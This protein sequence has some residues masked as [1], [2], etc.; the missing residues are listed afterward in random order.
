MFGN[1]LALVR[2]DEEFDIFVK[3][4]MQ[5]YDSNLFDAIKITA[6][7]L[8]NKDGENF[9]ILTGNLTIS[10]HVSIYQR[11][12]HTP[13]TTSAQTIKEAIH[14]GHYIDNEC[15]I[16]LLTDVYSDTKMNER[17]RN[18]LTREKVIEIIGR[19]DFHFKGASIQE[20]EAVFKAYG[21]Q[22]RI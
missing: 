10:S 13:I 9:D 11:Y 18:R 19:N 3:D 6:V 12:I 14:K 16:N 17:T 4:L 21:I 8:V 22:V 1:L 5:H 15:W 2:K 20:M 7:E